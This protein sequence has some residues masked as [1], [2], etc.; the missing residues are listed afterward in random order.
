MTVTITPID[1]NTNTWGDALARI[2]SLIDAVSNNAVT[3]GGNAANGDAVI[4]GSLTVNTANITDA[5]VVNVTSNTGTFNVL[6]A[7][8][9]NV[10]ILTANSASVVTFHANSFTA[11]NFSANNVESMTANNL[12]SNTANTE[13]LNANNVNANTANFLKLGVN[14]T[15]IRYIVTVGQPGA[16]GATTFN[17]RIIGISG[18]GGA[19]F[20]LDDVTS[21]IRATLG[22]FGDSIVSLLTQTAH[23][24]TLGANN[25]EVVRITPT[26]LVGVGLVNPVVK[27][28]V[29]DRIAGGNGGS[30]TR[31]MSDVTEP[32]ALNIID[33]QGAARVWRTQG[34]GDAFVEYAVGTA[35]SIASVER[36]MSGINAN[37]HFIRSF[38][39]TTGTD[40]LNISKTGEVGIGT[41]GNAVNTA[42]LELSSTT[43]GFL[44]P[45]MTTTQRNAI[46]NTTGLIIFNT[47]LGIPQFFSTGWK[48][49]FFSGNY[50]DLSGTPTLGGAAALNVGTTA[51][52]VA[53]GNDARITGAAQANGGSLTGGFAGTSKNLG[54]LAGSLTLTYVGGNIQHGVNNGATTINA[55][56]AAGVYTLVIEIVNNASAGTV[57][58]SGFTKTDG[59]SFTTT[60]G[61]KFLLHVAKTNSAVKAT[62]EALQ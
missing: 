32:R 24:L 29:S 45:R 33:T 17:D 47:T 6:N 60:N 50:A 25:A 52:T 31:I 8:T 48:D 57:T 12:I 61:H 22:T 19:G 30:N 4:N 26:S 37:G 27:L 56:S 43:K 36:W 14:T 54:N 10:D 2:N 40:R 13:V 34:T 58:L 62:V 23:P 9:A 44:P 51:N 46:A 59:D 38:S 42:V 35:T 5:N 1:I 3:V 18:S 53:A 15:D 41:G 55:P 28:H 7:N 16:N 11:D 21:D 20:K 49:A 39:G